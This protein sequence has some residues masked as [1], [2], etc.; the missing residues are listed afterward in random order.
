LPAFSQRHKAW[1]FR[2]LYGLAATA[3]IAAVVVATTAAVTTKG[4]AAAA[5]AEKD[6]DDDDDPGTTSVTTTTH[7]RAPPFIY[8]P[9]IWRNQKSVTVYENRRKTKQ[10]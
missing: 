10:I 3:A 6:Q 9:I 8:T 1:I 4:I 7:G 2:A 5:A